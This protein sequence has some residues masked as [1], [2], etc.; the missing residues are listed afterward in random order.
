MSEGLAFGCIDGVEISEL[1]EGDLAVER[2]EELLDHVEVCR[3]CAVALQTVVILK[4]HREE[5]IAL[6]H[7]AQDWK[8]GQPCSDR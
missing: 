5:A 1:A 7:A 3:E 6:L 4:A 2:L 8:E